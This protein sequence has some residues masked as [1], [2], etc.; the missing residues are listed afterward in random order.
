MARY[1]PAGLARAGTVYRVVIERKHVDG[2]EST[3][4]FGPYA[5][6]GA[7]AGQRTME[8]GPHSYYQPRNGWTTD[9]YIQTATVDWQR[10]EE[11]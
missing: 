1:M 8:A 2:R 10:E 6:R 5:T 3:V 11:G 4:V 7:A 9:A